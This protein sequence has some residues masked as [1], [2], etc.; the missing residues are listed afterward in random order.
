MLRLKKS[1][2]RNRTKDSRE[3]D[4]AD[5]LRHSPLFHPHR[6][7]IWIWERGTLLAFKDR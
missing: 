3:K 2:A 5:M 1:Y 4:L 6:P 7:L